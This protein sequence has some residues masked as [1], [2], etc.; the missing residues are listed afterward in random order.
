MPRGWFTVDKVLRQ[1]Q[2][3]SDSVE[4]D[5][6]LFSEAETDIS[7]DGESARHSPQ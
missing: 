4:E 6:Q 1:V 3:D 5:M 2:A 7:S